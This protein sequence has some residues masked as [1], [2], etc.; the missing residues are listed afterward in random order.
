MYVH[1]SILPYIHRSLARLVPEDLRTNITQEFVQGVTPYVVSVSEAL[2]KAA[3]DVSNLVVPA[4][5]AQATPA[6]VRAM[7]SHTVCAHVYRSAQSSLARVHTHAVWADVI[8]VP[9]CVHP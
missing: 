2:G 7:H 3:S 6:Q 5:A 8:M 4:V 9:Q 1:V